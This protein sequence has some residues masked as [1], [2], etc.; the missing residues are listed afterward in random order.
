MNVLRNVYNCAHRKKSAL[1]TGG[2][3]KCTLLTPYQIHRQIGGTRDITKHLKIFRVISN[4]MP[5]LLL[6]LC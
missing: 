1:L 4:E 3:L 2:T 6:F 5:I